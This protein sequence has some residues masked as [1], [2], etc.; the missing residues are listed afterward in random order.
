MKKFKEFCN[1]SLAPY[2]VGAMMASAFWCFVI[3]MNGG[4]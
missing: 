2:I 3:G 1:S 4:L